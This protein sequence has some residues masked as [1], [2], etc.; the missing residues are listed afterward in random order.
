[1]HGSRNAGPKY[2]VVV[3]NLNMSATVERAV[4]SILSQVDD[5]Y[6]VLVVDGGSTDGSLEIPFVF[7]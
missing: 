7:S 1:M 5:D 3:C 2:T 6:E 4:E